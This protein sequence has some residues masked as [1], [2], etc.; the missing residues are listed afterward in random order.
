MTPTHLLPALVPDC[1][2]LAALPLPQVQLMLTML[3]QL[4]VETVVVSDSGA[5]GS[6]AFAAN[7]AGSSENDALGIQRSTV[8]CSPVSS[9]RLAAARPLPAHAL[10]ART[11]AAACA[12]CHHAQGLPLPFSPCR[13]HQL[14]AQP[15]RVFG[16]LPFCG[17]FHLHRLPIPRGGGRVAASAQPAALRPHP[18]QRVGPRFQHRWGAPARE[19]WA[20]RVCMERRRHGGILA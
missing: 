3:E 20:G 15:F 2:L 6:S 10:S 16:P 9:C 12:A 1:C 17:L 8:L 14:G 19:G 11:N 18:R 13:R 4:Q 5:P 7:R